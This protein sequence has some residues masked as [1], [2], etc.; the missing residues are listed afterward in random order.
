MPRYFKN[1]EKSKI[2]FHKIQIS[3]NNIKKQFR[4]ALSPPIHP[5]P[6]MSS[7]VTPPPLPPRNPTL[8]LPDPVNVSQTGLEEK[9]S[10]DQLRKQSAESVTE[11]VKRIDARYVYLNFIWNYFL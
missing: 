10:D 7:Y 5:P 9:L 11:S 4:S 8:R 6:P 1:C 2:N 3:K